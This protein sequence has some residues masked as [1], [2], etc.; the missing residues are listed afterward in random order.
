M[1]SLISPF[2][3]LNE[4]DPDW[5]TSEPAQQGVHRRSKGSPCIT[6]K[7]R[8]RPEPWQ[9]GPSL[10]NDTERAS[11]KL[12]IAAPS[13]Q[14]FPL[15]KW[16]EAP[17]DGTVTYLHQGSDLSPLSAPRSNPTAPPS[18][19]DASRTQ[20]TERA[21]WDYL[22]VNLATEHLNLAKEVPTITPAKALFGSVGVLLNMIRYVL[23]LPGPNVLCSHMVRT[24]CSTN[25]TVSN[26]VWPARTYVGP[27][28]GGCTEGGWT[29][30]VNPCAKRSDN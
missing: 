22:P 13:R 7:P 1:E 26:S 17:H 4:V 15:P 6:N 20:T 14:S 24:R 29:S 3:A 23:P 16:R 19:D 5:A 2:T 28:I 12:S 9:G 10:R 8:A 25:W 30:S 21:G 27:S 18:F 11:S